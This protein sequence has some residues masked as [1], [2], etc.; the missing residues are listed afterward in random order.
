MLA[1]GGLHIVGTERHESRRIDNQLRGR[2]GRQGDPGSSRFYLALD[3]DLLRIFGTD[4]MMAFMEKMGMQDDEPIEHRMI[5]R[6]IENAQKKVEGHNFNIRKNLLEYDDVMNQQRKNVYGLRRRALA[7]EDVRG[8]IAD[9]IENL[10][11][12]F[13]E[14]TVPESV[15][16]EEWD[17][18][19]LRE[20]LKKVFG[21]EWSETDEEVRDHALEELRER[22]IKEAVAKLEAREQEIDK[23]L[24]NAAEQQVILSYTDQ[25]WKDHLLAMDRL[26]DGIGLRGYGQRN[27]L[28][29][30]KKEGFNM[31]LL[32]ASLRDEAIVSTL[33]LTA[34]DGLGRL[35]AMQGGMPVV[36][37]A[38]ARRLMDNP[39]AAIGG[40]AVAMAQ[41][42]SLEEMDAMA[43]TNAAPPLAIPANAQAPQRRR[44]KAGEEARAF[45]LANNVGRN[46]PCP[47]GSGRKFKKCCYKESETAPGGGESVTT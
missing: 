23:E 19:E 10:V 24:F 44:P 13:L 43:A 18:P 5:S 29:E 11:D 17:V 30:Y 12:D 8:I 35:V 34:E 28:L 39:A 22:L 38:A 4:R 9:A 26:R 47:C 16:P 21:I 3:D 14:E 46:D 45:A 37:K 41:G 32:M 42:K 2:S 20:R 15:Q 40:R 25:F 31:F 6:S 33:L 36:S 27:P 7:G 1:A